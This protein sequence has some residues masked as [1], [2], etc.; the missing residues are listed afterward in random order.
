MAWV[1]QWGKRR[2]AGV[3]VALMLRIEGKFATV[4]EKSS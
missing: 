3:E 1:A 2:N 4:P